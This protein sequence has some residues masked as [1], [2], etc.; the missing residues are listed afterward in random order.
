[1]INRYAHANPVFNRH[2]MK[3]IIAMTLCLRVNRSALA[4]DS[5]PL[6]NAVMSLFE[7]GI[8]PDKNQHYDEIAKNT[9]STS[10]D[11]EAGTLAMYSL[12]HKDDVNQAY[13]VETCKDKEAYNH[14]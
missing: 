2:H 3:K 13:M 1:M 7:P 9:I 5:I 6:G 14:I 11:Q 4:A 10:V 8:K 12:K